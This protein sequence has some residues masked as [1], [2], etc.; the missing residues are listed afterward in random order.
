M[1]QEKAQKHY[2]SVIS[3]VLTVVF[4]LFFVFTLISTIYFAIMRQQG[5]AVRIFGYSI[6]YIV[7]G[8][9]QDALMIGD[10]IVVKNITKEDIKVGDIVTYK[11]TEGALAGHYITHRIIEIKQHTNGNLQFV[12]KGDANTSADSE[13]VTYEK[14]LGI[15]QRKVFV[16][17][18][19]LSLLTNFY[20]F[21]LLIIL[22]LLVLFAFQIKNFITAVN[23]NDDNNIDSDNNANIVYNKD[24]EGSLDNKDNIDIIKKNKKKR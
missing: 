24:S 22:P 6:N 15:Y 20:V 12:T 7:T 10:V 16:L 11:S 5:K 19:L 14:V 23:E 18:I 1:K 2:K 21:F 17:T 8:S 3:K 4:I 9:M 13:V